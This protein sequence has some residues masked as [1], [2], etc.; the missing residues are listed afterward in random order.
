AGGEGK[1]YDKGIFDVYKDAESVQDGFSKSFFEKV[2]GRSNTLQLYE[3]KPAG[4]ET[5]TSIQG[6]EDILKNLGPGSPKKAVRLSNFQYVEVTP[7]N[8]EQIKAD[9]VRTNNVVQIVD[10]GFQPKGELDPIH[11][12]NEIISAD[13]IPD[14]INTAARNQRTFRDALIA[15]DWSSARY[16]DWLSKQLQE[17]DELIKAYFSNLPK[18]AKW[19]VVPYIY[20]WGKKGFDGLFGIEGDKYSAFRLPD[21]YSVLDFSPGNEEIYKDAYIDFFSHEGSDQ[22]D[23]FTRVINNMFVWGAFVVTPLVSSYKPVDDLWQKARGTY[24]RDTPENLAFY[25][26]GPDDCSACNL[27]LA[28]Q[29]AQRTSIHA[30]FHA[31]Q[32]Y[33]SILFED[34]VTKDAKEKGQVLVSFA[35]HAD[36]KGKLQGQEST[37]PINIAAAKGKNETCEQKARSLPLGVGL[38]ADFAGGGSAGGVLA[39]TESLTYYIFG[40]PGIFATAV[41]QLYFAPELND[42]VDDQEGYFANF[43]QSNPEAKSSKEEQDLSKFAS[44]NVLDGIRKAADK[45]EKDFS[46]GSLTDKAVRE[47]ATQVKDFADNAQEHRLVQGRL[48]LQGDSH[49]TL[50][51]KEMLWYWVAGGGILDKAA[52]ETEGKMVLIGGDNK[53][54]VIDNASG[55]ITVDGKPTLTEADH[56]RLNSINNQIPAIEVPNRLGKYAL[57]DNNEVLFEINVQG[58][59]VVRDS[60]AANCIQQA[61]FDQSGLVLNSP[62]LAD[63]FGLVQNV[64]TTTHSNVFPDP[65]N[66]Q[67][68]AE[69]LARKVVRGSDSRIQVLNSASVLLREH[70]VPSIGRLNSIQFKNGLMIYKPE[71]RELLIWLKHDE[72]AV[73]SKDD[74]TGFNAEL[75][76]TKNPETNCDEPA[77]DFSVTANPDNDQATERAKNFN[78]SIKKQGPFQTFETDSKIFVFYS[79]LVEGAC[80]DYFKVVDKKTGEVLVDQEISNIKQNPDGTIEVQTADGRNHT[81]EF[82][83]EGGQPTLKY[84]DGAPELLRSATGKNGS[85]YYDPKKGLYY[86]ENAQLIPTND[87]FRN[88]GLGVG[89]NPDGSVSAKPSGNTFII[90]PGQ[91]TGG[92]FNVASLPTNLFQ[93]GAFAFLLMIAFAIS[94]TYKKKP[95]ENVQ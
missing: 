38:I 53:T 45:A 70:E 60:L 83:E 17:E 19:T 68:V 76:Q 1:F 22:G 73:I 86:P 15:K 90:N 50:K 46:T 41:Q 58:E 71:T 75:T 94:Y 56:V 3:I 30:S 9:A 12:G 25:L 64:T 24:S 62:N 54:V 52:Y 88:K 67:I 79:K 10:A 26:Y 91:G 84:N 31:T 87:D 43:Y 66:N 85:F 95:E 8:L 36:I 49:G 42:C 74:V 47:V 40:L 89:V 72:R 23:I 2:P 35:H 37:N 82:G 44:N 92:L 61:V 81:L 16:G 33:S 28:S 13:F 27:S 18:A 57:P 14:K 21:E 48:E 69:G 5:P 11:F 63:A 65:T 6:L 59:L 7:N 29:D 93:L 77:V 80:K 32:N 34:R 39:I 51:S 78:T 20:V 55:T 4:I